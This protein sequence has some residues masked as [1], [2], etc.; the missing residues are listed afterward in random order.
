LLSSIIPLVSV[1]VAWDDA[2]R[3][4]G[5]NYLLRTQAIDDL[6]QLSRHA[7]D[8]LTALSHLKQCCTD[9]E[10]N[11]NRD[12][13]R[14]LAVVL[15]TFLY[16][17]TNGAM[18]YVD[19]FNTGIYR[20]LGPGHSLASCVQFFQG[21]K[22]WETLMKYRDHVSSLVPPKMI[23]EIAESWQERS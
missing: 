19:A 12:E 21:K 10:G 11:F 4:R 15:H 20:I 7:M 8:V 2:G 16:V 3:V 9:N 1:G 5:D 13:F 14:I 22:G 17:R 6:H 18:M 23:A